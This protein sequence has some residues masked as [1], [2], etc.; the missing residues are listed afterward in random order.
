MRTGQWQTRSG[1]K[2]LM[3]TTDKQTEDQIERLA[4]AVSTQAEVANRIWLG[5][6]TVSIVGL[7]PRVPIRD[8][9]GYSDLPLGLGRAADTSFH[10]IVFLILVVLAIA[11]SAAH[12]Q[13]I[14]AQALAQDFI[15]TLPQHETGTLGMHP[16]ELFD[17][18]RSPSLNRVAPL[19]Q[20]FRGRYQFY[21]S[22]A[23]CP[24]WLR[25]ASTLYYIPLKL[26]SMIVFFGLPAFSLCHSFRL[27]HVVGNLRWLVMIGGL[28][29]ASALALMCFS[30]LVY[31]NRTVPSIWSGGKTHVKT[32]GATD[33]RG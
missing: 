3:T 24:A 1:Q 25:I 29:A 13:Q 9:P 21:R 2:S 22:R 7:L 16:R 8:S 23:S 19:A 33:K 15:N 26:A 31:L 18:L 30:E 10:L 20:L 32:G 4:K 28:L 17:F 11:F 27:T 6:V 12:A 5:L 14:R